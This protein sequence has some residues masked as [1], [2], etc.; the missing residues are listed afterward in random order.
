MQI[1]VQ[2]HFHIRS[3]SM[4]RSDHRIWLSKKSAFLQNK[5]KRDSFESLLH[6]DLAIIF[7][8]I[9]DVTQLDPSN[10]MRRKET[11]IHMTFYINCDYVIPAIVLFTHISKKE[12]NNAENDDNDGND[13]NIQFYEIEHEISNSLGQ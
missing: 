5:K 7:I 3:F 1:Q 2:P 9:L 12:K 13:S 11:H 4:T 6:Q 8:V 10:R